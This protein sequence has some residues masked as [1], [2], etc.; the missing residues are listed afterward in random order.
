MP[1]FVTIEEFYTYEK[2]GFYSIRIEDNELM[3]TEKFYQRFMNDEKY[4]EEFSDLIAWIEHIGEIEGAAPELFRDE[5]DAQA[6]PPE[7]RQIERRAMLKQIGYSLR[8]YCLRL[9]DRVVILLNG[10]IKESQKVQDSPDLIGKFRMANKISRK[11]TEQLI[12]R[13][14]IVEGKQLAGDLELYL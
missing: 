7:F 2:V 9:S 3:E 10:G 12:R 11:I 13:E 6:L 1:Q 14:L 5:E 4:K 8:L